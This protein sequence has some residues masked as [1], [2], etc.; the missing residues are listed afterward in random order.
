M[1]LLDCFSKLMICVLINSFHIFNVLIFYLGI[2]VELVELIIVVQVVCSAAN[3]YCLSLFFDRSRQGV[4]LA[5]NIVMD[6]SED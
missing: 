6:G 3:F 4:A 1:S 2:T 5:K